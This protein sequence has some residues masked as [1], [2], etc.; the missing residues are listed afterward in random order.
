MIERVSLNV[1]WNAILRTHRWWHNSFQWP[2]EVRGW[3]RYLWGSVPQWNEGR[4][5]FFCCLWVA[6]LS[7]AARMFCIMGI[8]VW[9]R[10]CMVIRDDIIGGV[11]FYILL[12]HSICWC[13]WSLVGRWILG[14]R[15]GTRIPNLR[16]GT[17]KLCRCNGFVRFLQL[18]DEV[19]WHLFYHQKMLREGWEV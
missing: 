2:F 3:S 18:C 13:L 4:F 5:H 8:G 1:A 17:T 14:D 15:W 7:V 16:T 19:W 10:T 11:K 9:S 6:V 12:T